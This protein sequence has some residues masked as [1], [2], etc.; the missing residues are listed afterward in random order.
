MAITLINAINLDPTCNV[1][2]GAFF[3]ISTNGSI[4]AK[5]STGFLYYKFPANSGLDFSQP[6]YVEAEF[7]YFLQEPYP[8]MSFEFTSKTNNFDNK[9]ISMGNWFDNI[10]EEISLYRIWK[11]ENVK[12]VGGQSCGSTFDSNHLKECH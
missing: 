7:F 8:T 3:N 4:Q 11:L 2:D 10:T 1:G 6:I 12:S 9:F 5:S